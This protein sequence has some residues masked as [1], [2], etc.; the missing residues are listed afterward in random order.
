VSEA[1][2]PGEDRFDA[3]EREHEERQR[4]AQGLA[5]MLGTTAEAR[6]PEAATLAE[7]QPEEPEGESSARRDE[8]GRFT[9]GS[10]DVAEHGAP[11]L[12]TPNMGA[13]ILAHIDNDPSYLDS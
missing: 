7:A 3:L 9:A 4:A 5:G 12:P 11:V 8:Q 1:R 10:A 2:E 6:E 13:M